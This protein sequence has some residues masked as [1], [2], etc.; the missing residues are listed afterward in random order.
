MGRE[1]V[2]AQREGRRDGPRKGGGPGRGEGRADQHGGEG[3]QAPAGLGRGGLGRLD[4]I[5]E[6]NRK[7][8]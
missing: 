7:M 8:C 6:G 1:R 4:L 3:G 2:A 5:G